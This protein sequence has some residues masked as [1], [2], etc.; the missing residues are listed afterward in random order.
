MIEVVKIAKNFGGLQVLKDISLTV[1]AGQRHG[2]IGPNG[3]GKTTL[4]NIISGLEPPTSGSI[5]WQG[6]DITTLGPHQRARLGMG[7]TFQIC[8]LLE[9]SSVR[10][11]FIVALAAVSRPANIWQRIRS[12]LLRAVDSD[13]Q[14][15]QA[16]DAELERWG[17][18]SLA[19]RKAS[20]LAYGQRRIVDIA[21]ASFAQPQLLLLDEPAAG[22]SPAESEQLITTLRGLRDD[23]TI[24]LVDHDIDL[25]FS[26]CPT[27][28]VLADGYVLAHG[29]SDEIRHNQDVIESYIGEQV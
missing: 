12:N 20:A 1:E 27:V 25:V 4:M 11:N 17:L 16:A 29:A 23:V 9:D 6:R 7:R 26:I 21:M 5:M 24:L 3:A 15:H 18:T 19:Q 13:P 22:L 28:T 2:L 14:L 10:H 8:R